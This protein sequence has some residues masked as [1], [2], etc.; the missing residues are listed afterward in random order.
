[1]KENLE[2]LISGIIKG[3]KTNELDGRVESFTDYKSKYVILKPSVKVEI[4]L[5]DGKVV[6]IDVSDYFQEVI[7]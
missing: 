7:K 4:S 5:T 6:K 1:M 3:V 2:E